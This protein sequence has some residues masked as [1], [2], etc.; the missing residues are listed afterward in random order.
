MHCARGQSYDTQ[1]MIDQ[2][3]FA[4]LEGRFQIGR[5]IFGCVQVLG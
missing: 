4:I 5:D 2:R 3:R 1:G